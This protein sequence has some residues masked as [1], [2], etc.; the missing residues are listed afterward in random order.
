M[1]C[2]VASQ[3]PVGSLSLS[4]TNGYGQWVFGHFKLQFS[5][6]FKFKF[7]ILNYNF[8]FKFLFLFI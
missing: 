5:K 6:F 2:L 7:L 3:L 4:E 8:Y 1:R